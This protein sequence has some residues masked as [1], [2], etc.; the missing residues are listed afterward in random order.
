MKRV[1][2]SNKSLF[3]RFIVSF[4]F[5]Q[6]LTNLPVFNQIL[7]ASKFSIQANCCFFQSFQNLV[8]I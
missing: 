2:K 5:L 8:E 4:S 1:Q 6:N 3:K 7:C